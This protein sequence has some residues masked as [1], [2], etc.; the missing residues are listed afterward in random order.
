M[1][2]GSA[3]GLAHIGVIQVLQEEG[4]PIDLVVGSSMG[5]LIGSFWGV[6][7]DMYLLPRLLKELNFNQFLDMQVPGMGFIAGNRMEEFIRVLTHGKTF[8]ELKG[9]LVVVATDLEAGER[10]VLQEGP[11]FQAVRASISIPGVIK[12]FTLNNRLLVDGAVTDRLPVSVARELDADLVVAVDVTFG[13]HEIKVHNIIDV[14]LQSISLLEKQIHETRVVEADIV[15]Q[16][17]VANLGM[18]RFD[19]IEEAV[20]AG[21]EAT[22]LNIPKIKEALNL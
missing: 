15:I 5:A 19:L 16:P 20:T 13:E 11:V 2:A 12:P 10:I 1:G 22:I 4:I 8:D 18:T 7:L 21:R 14:F 17:S 6:G 9:K 3:R